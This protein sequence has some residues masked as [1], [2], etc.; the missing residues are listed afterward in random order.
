MA[1]WIVTIH[2]TIPDGQLEGELRDVLATLAPDI[3]RYWWA[4]VDFE[5]IGRGASLLEADAW[6]PEGRGAFFT[7]DVLLAVAREIDQTIAATLIAAP[8]DAFAP[9]EARRQ[10]M[11]LDVRAF[12][13]TQAQL[14]VQV[15]DSA[16]FEIMTKDYRHVQALKERFRDVRDEDPANYAF[17]PVERRVGAER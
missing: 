13:Y 7:A 15:V 2:D 14:I 1:L 16:F 8:P 11:L 3:R 4:V 9:A 17:T 6:Q 12:P 10:E 5:G